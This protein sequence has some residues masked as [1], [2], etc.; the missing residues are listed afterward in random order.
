M[1]KENKAQ[2]EAIQTI[3]GQLLLVACPGS[4]KTTTLIR[5][6]N[7]MITKGNVDPRKILMITF[8][9]AAAEEMEKRYTTMYEKNPGVTFSTIHSLCYQMVK[10]FGK[11]QISLLTE[12]EVFNYFLF[13]VKYIDKINDKDEFVSDL[14]LDI[15]VMKNN[16]IRLSDYK[17]N[18]T[19]DKD[20][21]EKLYVGYE[22]YK[23][24]QNKLD[25]DDM[26]VLAKDLL[27]NNEKV[28]NFVRSNHQYIQ[29]DEYQ[30]T[31]YLQRDIIYQMAG[32]NGNLAVVGDDDQSIY[33]FRG[34]K[35]EIMLNFT[36][37]YPATK[38]IHMNTNYRSEKNI[39]KKAD[40]LVKHN[41][42]RFKKDFIGSRPG[43]GKVVYRSYLNQLAQLGG[44][45]YKIK[46]LMEDGVKPEQIAIL[47]RTN[48]EST[49]FVE[50]FM[51][52]KIPFR[53]NEKL[54]SKYEH[55]IFQDIQAYQ[56]LSRGANDQIAFQKILNHP[57]RFFYGKTYREIKPDYDSLSQAIL[58]QPG[59]K[60]WQLTKALEEAQKLFLDLKRLED[61]NPEAFMLYLSKKIGYD[62]YIKSYEKSRNMKN[63][64]LQKIWKDFYKEAQLYKDWNIWGK[65]I[66]A[67]NYQLRLA[68]KNT[69]GITLST[70]HRA[71]G[72]EWDYV[73]I[74]NCMEGIIPHSNAA[75]DEEIEE[76]RRLFYVAMTRAKN[77]LFISS[78]KKDEESENKNTSRFITECSLA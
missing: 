50:H 29:V 66:R 45:F 4:G 12:F 18:C 57:N 59:K 58:S 69:N 47:Y 36:K 41:Q 62:D 9:K 6:I 65:Y 71:K 52:E 32:E 15:S 5:R 49:P 70:M 25:F 56:R 7:Y 35:P 3:N 77:S 17:P 51:Q 39:I 34:A 27:E 78:Y 31:N 28:L 23:E 2:E 46:K 67:Y 43:E 55:W 44:I 64:E 24:E 11:R 72:L 53:C 60:M 14:I 42:K 33:A 19:D 22:K 13:R 37:D 38:V 40:E 61:M 68:D 48:K 76:E 1:L 73:F 26:L 16:M 21:F 75:T 54:T 8:T 20:L 10:L 63:K 30:D 74:V